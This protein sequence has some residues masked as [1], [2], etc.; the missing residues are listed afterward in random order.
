MGSDS[1]LSERALREIYL[2]G[3]EIAIK[4]SKPMSIMTSYNL[5]NGVHAANCY[6]T[7][8]QAARQEWG[9]DG[10]IMTD[11]TTTEHGP[12]C[13]ASGCMRAGNDLVMP[14]RSSDHDN[15]R[16]ELKNGTLSEEDLRKCIT[17]LV[18]IVLRS[19]LYE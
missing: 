6:D 11:W 18:R 17:R 7:C 3:F 12:D 14:G 5:I 13:T 16:E 2:K 10:V 9:F 1:I 15:M 4:E 8:T 19:N